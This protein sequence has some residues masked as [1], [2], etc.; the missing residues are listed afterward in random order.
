M[1]ILI[2]APQ[3]VVVKV[4]WIY[5]H[6]WL[7]TLPGRVSSQYMSVLII[8]TWPFSI[9]NT[10]SI[11]MVTEFPSQVSPWECKRKQLSGTPEGGEL[12]GT[13]DGEEG[14]E[15]SLVL[16]P[17][18]L[19]TVL[20]KMVRAPLKVHL[21]R[22]WGLPSF[23]SS[24]PSSSSGGHFVPPAGKRENTL[25]STWMAENKKRYFTWFRDFCWFSPSFN[26]AEV[27]L[28]LSCK[29]KT[30][31]YSKNAYCFLESSE[32]QLPS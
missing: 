25:P 15:L 19:T 6:E 10:P 16:T 27:K 11:I 24:F 28:N 4:T 22:T 23:Y 1:G 12:S 5:V 17:L 29:R 20:Y 18:F 7:R 8:T 32:T 9:W 31:D 3:R 26:E 14:F 30:R 13:P 2:V 21:C